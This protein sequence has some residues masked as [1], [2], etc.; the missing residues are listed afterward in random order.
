MGT[1]AMVCVQSYANG[2]Y[3]LFYRHNDGNPDALGFE[4]V[5]FLGEVYRDIELG[6]VKDLTPMQFIDRMVTALRLQPE[7]RTVED[8]QNAFLKVQGDLEYLYVIRLDSNF[9]R[10]RFDLYK[11]SNPYTTVNFVFHVMGFYMM[12]APQ[13]VRNI[14]E[15]MEQAELISAR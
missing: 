2:I 6:F 9:R 14:S 13:R 1:R 11:T 12:F 4:L 10:T 3:E 7:N 15:K 5:C 8:F